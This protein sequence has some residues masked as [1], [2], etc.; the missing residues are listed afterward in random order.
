M[1]NAPRR[2][3]INGKAMVVLEEAEYQRLLH[4]ADLWEPALPEPDAAGNYPA[5]EAMAVIQARDVLR[6]R[7]RLGLT[8]AELARAAGV[9]LETVH[10][11][12]TAKNKPNVRTMEK[13]DRALRRAGRRRARAKS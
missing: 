1:T 9:R 13:I 5:L 8:Q 10:R 12:E 2:R 6:E 4:K 7:R 3:I 11:I